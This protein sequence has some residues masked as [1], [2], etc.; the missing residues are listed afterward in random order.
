MT[1]RLSTAQH[2]YNLDFPGSSAGKESAATQ[3]TPVLFLGWEDRLER[4]MAAH[5]CILAWEIP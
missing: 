1:E 2:I 5:S 3:E 4:G